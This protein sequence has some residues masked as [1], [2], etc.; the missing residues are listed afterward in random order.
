M[1]R[2]ATGSRGRS[3]KQAIRRD[4]VAVASGHGIAPALR[5]YSERPCVCA[6]RGLCGPRC[7]SRILR[8][9]YP[10]STANETTQ[11]VST[12]GGKVLDSAC[13]ASSSFAAAHYVRANAAGSG[14]QAVWSWEPVT[15]LVALLTA[16]LTTLV[17]ATLTVTAVVGV[18]LILCWSAQYC[19]LSAWCL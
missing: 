9:P 7:T 17:R 8:L 2:R 3:K 14:V 13:P 5:R 11:L 15:A 1:T 16:L 10:R 19:S 4:V 6:D 18:V 12:R